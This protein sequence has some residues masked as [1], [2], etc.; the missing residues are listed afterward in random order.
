MTSATTQILPPASNSGLQ[1]PRDDL[2]SLWR[3]VAGRDNWAGMLDPI[4]PLLRAELMRYGE[5]AQACYDAFDFDPYSRY[6]GGCKYTPRCFFESLGKGNAGYEVTRYL[7]ATLDKRSWSESANWI[8]YVAVSDDATTARLGRRDIAVCWRGTVTDLEKIAD[9]TEVQQPV[10]AEGIP[11]PDRSVKVMAGFVNLYTDK[12]TADRYSKYSVRE[13]VL[14]EVRRQVL[15]YAEERGEEVSISI[16]GHSLGSALA[17]LSAYDLAEVGLNR[18]APAGGKERVLPVT[19]YSFAGPRLGNES[20]KDRFEKALGLKCLRVLNVHDVVPTVPGVVINEDTPGLL[21]SAGALIP[22]SYW[23]VGV[24]LALDYRRSP[25]LQDTKFDFFGF[26]NLETHLHLLD[27]HHGTGRSFAM[28]SGRDPALVNKSL[29]FLKEEH[30]VPPKWRQDANRGL[31]RTA[32]GRWTQP[33][34][35]RDDDHPADID[36]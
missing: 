26:H 19:V 11:T 33:A 23:H 14:A 30:M 15:R 3:D 17:T 22:W 27:G 35:T 13:Q 18:L 36:D 9:L 4:D 20:F 10:H 32:N 31:T 5:F 25:F 6:C 1:Q 28:V 21:R 2:P 16:T 7:Y 24:K 8:G 34:R 12:N 29:D